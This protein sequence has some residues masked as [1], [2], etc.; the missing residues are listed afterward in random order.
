MSS[1]VE[2]FSLLTQNFF[3]LILPFYHIFKCFMTSEG[4]KTDQID[5]NLSIRSINNT[6]FGLIKG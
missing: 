4:V 2:I 5:F 6:D 3:F 1:L